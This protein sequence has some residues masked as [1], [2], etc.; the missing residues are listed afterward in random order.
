MDLIITPEPDTL[1]RI[2]MI[3][4]PIDKKISIKEQELTHVKRSGYT[5]VEWGGSLVK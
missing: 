2:F 3:Y 1:I 4:K 5:V